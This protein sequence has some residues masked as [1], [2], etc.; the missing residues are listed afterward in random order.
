MSFPE[1]VLVLLLISAD[2][3]KTCDGREHLRRCSG[4]AE[5]AALGGRLWEALGVPLED[6]R[7]GVL[8]RALPGSKRGH[9]QGQRGALGD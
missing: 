7:R 5:P 4:A 3:N 8:W 2:A 6:P 1:A 9:R